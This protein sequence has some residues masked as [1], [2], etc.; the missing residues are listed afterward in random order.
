MHRTLSS[1]LSLHFSDRSHTIPETELD[2]FGHPRIPFR[3]HYEM[4]KNDLRRR[5]AESFA[6]GKSLQFVSDWWNVDGR[7]VSSSMTQLR[8]NLENPIGLAKIPIGLVGPVLIHGKHVDGYIIC[9]FATTEGSLVASA[10][11]GATACNR[12][13]GITTHSFSQHIIRA[14][15][16]VTGTLSQ[17]TELANCIISYIPEL[18]ERVSGVSRHSRLTRVEPF[19]VGRSVHVQ[20]VCETG[21]GA[22]QNMV[23]SVTSQACKWILR[24]VG[25]TRKDIV[26]LNYWV[27]ANGASDKKF[28]HMLNS[29]S[30]VRG[31]RG[32][33]SQADVYIPESLLKSVL[34]VDSSSLLSCFNA[35]HQ[36]SW[37][38]G[39]P[40]TVVNVSNAI[41]AIFSATGQD[42]ASTV[43]SSAAYFNM[44]PATP[45]EIQQFC[46]VKPKEPEGGIYISTSLPSVIVGTVGGGTGLA[47]QQECLQLMGCTGEN[48]NFRLAEI[49]AA[50][51]LSLDLSTLS[52]IASGQFAAA[53]ER[54]GKNHPN[55][56]IHLHHLNRD[57]FSCLLGEGE[58]LV[59]WTPLEVDSRQSILSDLAKVREFTKIV[60]H[61]GYELEYKSPNSTN[62]ETKRVVIKVKATGAEVCNMLNKIAQGCGGELAD[63][64]DDFKLQTGFWHTDQREMSAMSLEDS[65]F[66]DIAP[67]VYHVWSDNHKDIFVIAMEKLE[68]V[69]H[70][71]T[72]HDISQWSI[73]D[74]KVALSG[75]ARFHSLY[76][77]RTNDLVN[78]Q[79]WFKGMD[80]KHMVKL[81]PLWR[82]LVKQNASEFPE[83][84]TPER[85]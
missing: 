2:G 20:F 79:P 73:N 8:G 76:L 66:L 31:G 32:V 37:L 13:G 46:R 77:G 42:I 30:I 28:S 29:P 19:I 41:A 49:I 54:L 44:E 51:T 83:M 4:E 39:A 58:E 25:Q 34:K 84:W 11:R 68:D 67:E 38:I 47:T 61:L 16:F 70:F 82:A 78:E 1:T 62:M 48:G 6:G 23:T 12:A 69:S 26:I 36:S 50:I 43:E 85:Y 15:C 57:F 59:G 60:G 3:G 35:F 52:A 74:I 75:I 22:G 71:D 7:D 72:V 53:H 45:E 55:L 14:P 80:Q 17:A 65:Q 63:I 33:H 10:T 64:Y 5:W 56:G 24:E 21:E 18:K 40:T 9:P 27:E 81:Q